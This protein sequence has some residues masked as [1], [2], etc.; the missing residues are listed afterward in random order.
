MICFR[1]SARRR[2][3]N[4]DRNTKHGRGGRAPARDGKRAYDRRSGTG[5]GKEIKKGG[6]GARNWGNDKAEAKKMEGTVN[7]DEVK[8]D[9]PAAE[10]ESPAEE[11][12]APEPEPEPEP[13]NTMTYAEYMASKKKEDNTSTREVENEFSGKTAAKKVEEDFLVLGAGKS[14]KKKKGKETKQA[15]EVG[16]RVVSRLCM[17]SVSINYEG[18]IQPMFSLTGTYR[19]I[20]FR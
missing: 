16:F 15:V 5:R 17:F 18:V 4:N 12:Q 10:G 2:T 20:S 8:E 11:T 3:P 7:E 1:F 19:L 6:G 13:D 14:K 9:K